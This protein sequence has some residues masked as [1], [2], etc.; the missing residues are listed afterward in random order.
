MVTIVVIL[1]F[2]QF[3]FMQ[4]Q[5]SLI[6]VYKK[7]LEWLQQLLKF[8]LSTS[9]D[10][11]RLFPV[12]QPYLC[13]SEM[14]LRIQALMV[15]SFPVNDS[16]SII[17][18]DLVFLNSQDMEYVKLQLSCEVDFSSEKLLKLLLNLSSVSQNVIM[19]SKHKLLDSLSLIFETENDMEQEI[20]AQLIQRIIEFESS[21]Q[22]V[23]TEEV[24]IKIP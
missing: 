23:L 20:A 6:I 17:V 11:K 21:T 19:M 12:L 22:A 10:D 5:G 14:I 24:L 4:L 18:S 1:T 13:S 7:A 9:D 2:Y 15:V 8:N 3:L 16:A